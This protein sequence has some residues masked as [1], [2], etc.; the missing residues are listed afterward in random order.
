[1]G[2][3]VD[4]GDVGGDQGLKARPWVGSGG[5]NVACGVSSCHLDPGSGDRRQEAALVAEVDVWRLMAHADPLCHLADAEL[6]RGLG[7]EHFQ[8]GVDEPAR[9]LC[10]VSTHFSSFD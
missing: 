7:L 9:Q 1:M 2:P 5:C 6:L 8:G 4:E 10:L 3:G